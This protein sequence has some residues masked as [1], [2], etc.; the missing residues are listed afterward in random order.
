MGWSI[1]GVLERRDGRRKG[2]VERTVRR[3]KGALEGMGWRQ[4]GSGKDRLEETRSSSRAGLE[5]GPGSGMRSIPVPK[6]L[7]PIPAAPLGRA[8]PAVGA[9]F[10]T[11]QRGAP[12]SANP[13][14]IKC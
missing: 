10:G 7:T 2:A 8:L 3:R 12:G 1:K 5:Q 9:A 11:S 13:P 4:K 14:S 6:A